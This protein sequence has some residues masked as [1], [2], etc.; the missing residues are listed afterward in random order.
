M[1]EATLGYLRLYCKS[2]TKIDI[3]RIFHPTVTKYTYLAANRTF[4][5]TDPIVGHEGNFNKSNGDKT[6]ICTLP[7]NN[8]I[9]LEVNSKRQYHTTLGENEKAPRSQ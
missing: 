1:F 6:T 8:E 9:E 7:D 4:S 2:K 5:K 3:H